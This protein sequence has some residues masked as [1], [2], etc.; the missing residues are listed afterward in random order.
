MEGWIAYNDLTEEER[1][2]VQILHLQRLLE[3]GRA[4][5]KEPL[6]MTSERDTKSTFVIT[7]KEK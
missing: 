1:E 6:N 2:W 3:Q 5:M 4:E 7:I